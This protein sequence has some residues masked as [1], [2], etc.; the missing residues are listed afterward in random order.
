MSERLSKADSLS[1]LLSE[2]RSTE[3][4]MVYLKEQ[5]SYLSEK[6]NKLYDR[7]N[8]LSEKMGLVRPYRKRM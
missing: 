5:L 8:R 2:I 7:A 3:S 4:D 1:N 6:R